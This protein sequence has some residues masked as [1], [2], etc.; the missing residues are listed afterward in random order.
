MADADRAIGVVVNGLAEE[1]E[2]NGIKYNGV[3]PGV[4]LSDEDVANVL[5]FVRNSWGNQ[6]GETTPTDVA[7]VK[8][9]H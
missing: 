4:R 3:M 1:I 5:T 9:S 7:R 6:G 2:V 8:S